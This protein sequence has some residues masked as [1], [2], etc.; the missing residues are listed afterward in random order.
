MAEKTGKAE[1]KQKEGKKAQEKKEK[2]AEKKT[3]TEQ[4]IRFAETNIDG[5]QTVRAAIRRVR[6]VSFMYGNAVSRVSGFGGRR[7]GD[8]SEQELKTLED[9]ITNPAKHNIPAWLYN[10]RREPSSGRDKHLIAS[11]MEFGRR[12]DINE[13]KRLKIYKGIRHGLGLPVRGQRTRSTFRK[14]KVVG[15]K[16]A[17]K[18][19]S[20]AKKK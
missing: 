17:K 12:M 11:T 14:G 18:E 13:M 2:P 19:R 1:K 6:G 7:I 16:K 20:Q 10:R 3:K 4:I 8:L 5:R 9:I 15:V